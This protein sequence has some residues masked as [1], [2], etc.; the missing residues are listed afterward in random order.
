MPHRYR[1]VQSTRDGSVDI[2]SA[3]DELGA[4]Q[5]LYYHR[6]RPGVLTAVDSET[7]RSYTLTMGLRPVEEE[8]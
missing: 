8:G 5:R 1:I 6:G 4:A 3:Y 7:G 2:D